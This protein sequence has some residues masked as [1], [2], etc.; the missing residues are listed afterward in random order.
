MDET[1]DEVLIKKQKNQIKRLNGRITYLK[2][3]LLD[4]LQSNNS[5]RDFND[6][7]IKD[8]NIVSVFESVLTRTL[9]M[10]PN[11]LTEDIIIVQAYH[12]KVLQNLIL[13]GFTYKNEKYVCF[14]ASAGQIR[15]KKTLF[16]KE[17][18]LGQYIKSL[19]CGL[20]IE[21]INELGGVNIN[22]FLAYLALC[23]SATEQWIGFDIDKSI[24]VEDMETNVQATVDF[25]D[26]KTYS[27]SRKEMDI[28]ITHTDG[29][30]MILPRTQGKAVMI[31]M[32][33][34]KGLLVPFPFDKFIR[35]KNKETPMNTGIVK[36]IYGKEYD[37]LKDKI[38]VIFTKSQFKMWKYYSSWDEYKLYYKQY[39]CQA[40]M[41]NEEEDVI[42]NAKLNYQMIQTLTD[43]TEDEL[44]EL[45]SS[46]KEVITSLGEDRR[47][48]LK[49]LG[50]TESN[51]NKNY[52]QQALDIYP[53]LL[54]DV[55]SREIIK[56]TKKSLIKNAK[57]GK[58]DIEGKYT[59]ISPDL[60]AFCEFIFLKE[61]NPKG[62]LSNG[63]IF[64]SLYNHNEKLDCLRSPHLYREHAIRMNTI[65]KEMKRWYVTKSLYTSCQDPIS[66]VLMFDNDGDKSLVSNDITL[67]TVAE[68]NM[69]DIVPLYYNMAKAGAELI[70]TENIYNGL[71]AAYTGGNIGVISNDITKIW[72]SND[73]NLDVIKI[74]CMENNF[75]IDY[76]KT[77]YKPTRPEKINRLITR[78]TRT[79]VPHFF[80]HA[81]DKNESNVEP[82]SNS[83]VNRMGKLIPNSRINFNRTNIG[84]FDYINLMKSLDV[85]MNQD[86]IEKYSKLDLKKRFISIDYDENSSSFE[87]THTYRKIRN[88]LLET[89]SDPYYVVD[90][91]VKYLYGDKNSSHK[92][93]LWSTFGDIIVENLKAN[94]H[95][96]YNH[97]YIACELCGLRVLATNNAKKYCADCSKIIIRAQVKEAKKKYREKLKKE[98]GIK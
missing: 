69:K 8:K 58:I 20:S 36:D 72:N 32:P 74:L 21:R 15:T 26:D 91:L 85:E 63:D 80:I 77:L 11:T 59:F 13:D 25:I 29:C 82:M 50:V 93:T 19:M 98:K 48:M 1:Q 42:G 53:E 3:L 60:Y 57:A 94:I 22:K 76:A 71:K 64:C 44:I 73:I 70:N 14:T 16:I 27:I 78:Y 79:K 62:L 52:F 45:T 81:K 61:S 34:M 95:N 33:W 75:T 18:I 4:K 55:Y 24:V 90:I 83:T 46:T 97:K 68:R 86:I 5:V 67:V 35:E 51:T 31:R 30:G 65:T 89:N 43:I 49:V 17:S 96:K 28:P 2:S 10:E 56:Q 87:N 66:K 40:G 6:K 9:G 88:E 38:E 37:I 12:F 41:C 92:T 54:K 7:Y 23:N 39:G 47:T 84:S